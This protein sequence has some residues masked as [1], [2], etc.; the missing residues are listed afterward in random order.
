M[1]QLI[2]ESKW[3]ASFF[4][5][6][7][8][9]SLVACN[10]TTD[11]PAGEAR[12]PAVPTSIGQPLPS[13]TF[14]PPVAPTQ[15]PVTVAPTASPPTPLAT[16]VSTPSAPPNP[17]AQS[18]REPAP[19]ATAAPSVATKVAPN[20]VVVEVVIEASSNEALVRFDRP[21]HVRGEIWLETSGGRSDNTDVTGSKT[22][23]FDAGELTR[24]VEIRGIGYGSGAAL[25]DIDGNDALT[26]FQPATWVVGNRPMSRRARYCLS[27]P[28]EVESVAVSDG[29]W[30]VTFTK[31]VLVVGDVVLEVNGGSDR[32]MVEPADKP[33]TTPVLLFEGGGT[34]TG[35]WFGL[36]DG[37]EV[38][39]STVIRD[40][41]GGEVNFDLDPLTWYGFPRPVTPT[42]ADCIHDAYS[43]TNIDSIRADTIA[44]TDPDILSDEQRFAWYL[45][46]D[47][48]NSEL[49]HS[50]VALW[51]E[52]ITAL[53]AEK[54]NEEYSS[55]VAG[56]ESR[57][58]QERVEY[59][60]AWLDLLIL[61]ERPYTSLTAAERFT[62]RSQLDSDNCAAYYP[63][64]FSGRW[65][66]IPER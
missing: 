57:I 15:P 28:A 55:C 50:C 22:L 30:Q 49:K 36:R 2:M 52:E 23:A 29:Y 35:A 64:L 39:L 6:A 32:H 5:C 14:A 41:S 61:L 25:R 16:T 34:R 33:T 21:V 27:C 9:F 66:P 46:L 62:L 7:A 38:T 42:M 53:N 24:I 31:P 12:G 40:P 19:A 11:S 10:P 48:T 65:I 47:K 51:S 4:I 54:R 56:V 3:C 37:N 26:E 44:S 59:R 43:S 63:Q 17:T 8:A 58:R 1:S 18:G 20:P 60:A 45:F 13:S